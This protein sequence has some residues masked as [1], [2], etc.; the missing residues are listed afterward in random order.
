MGY[1]YS[2]GKVRARMAG[3]P[4]KLV[5]LTI[6]GI[7]AVV[8]PAS[9]YA[10]QHVAASTDGGNPDQSS[11]SDATHKDVSAAAESDNTAVHTRLHVNATSNQPVSGSQNT[12][13]RVSASVSGNTSAT[14]TV[15][16]RTTTL[17]PNSAIDQTISSNNSTTN[18][19]VTLKGENRQNVAGSSSIDIQVDS[20]GNQ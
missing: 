12:S 15:N 9:V 16:G 18:L 2:I 6:V 17:S 8:V 4:R 10:W 20:E 3:M 13:G 19:N 11:Q 14:V 1:F 7:A 5:S